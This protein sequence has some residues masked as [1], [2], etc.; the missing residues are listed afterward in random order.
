MNTERLISSQYLWEVS[1]DGNGDVFNPIK[2][3]TDMGMPTVTRTTD[4][5]TTTDSTSTLTAATAPKETT[6]IA[7]TLAY[8]PTDPQHKLIK[9]VYENGTTVLNQIKFLEAGGAGYR[10]NGKIRQFVIKPEQKKMLRA[11]GI[12]VI[13]SEITS[14][15][16]K[17]L[18]IFNYMGSNSD[19]IGNSKLVGEAYLEILNPRQP[20]Q[21]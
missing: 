7:F 14:D 20:T 9:Q 5:I 16:E 10:F 15:F 6:E 1:V 4:D 3:L 11:E 13:E 12:L 19:L 17:F 8:I 2:F 21:P 18:K